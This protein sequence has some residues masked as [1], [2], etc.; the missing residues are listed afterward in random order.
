MT[1]RVFYSFHYKPDCSRAAQIR[2]MGIVDGNRPASDNDWETIKKGGDD[3]I[4][5]WINDQL[6]EKS[7]VVVLIGEKT[8]GRKWI[9]YEIKKGWENRKGVVGIY[10]H[11]LK[12][13]DGKQSN[14]GNNPFDYFSVGD[15]KLSAIVKAY[16]PIYSDSKE[17]YN[18]IKTNLANWIEEAI[19]IRDRY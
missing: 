14:K 2:N 18:Y 4:K 16:N 8:S 5:K 12:D 13:L 9:N 11:N 15:E 19:L 3:A 6:N 10:I 1:R 17:A 7:C